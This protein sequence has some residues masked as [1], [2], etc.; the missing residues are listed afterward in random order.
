MAG[1]SN[2]WWRAKRGWYTT[3]KATGEQKPLGVRDPEDRAG[4]WAALQ[5]LLAVAGELKLAECCQFGTVAEAVPKFLAERGATVEAKTI[6]GYAQ[7]LAWLLAW[8][9]S[10]APTSVTAALLHSKAAS[11]QTWGET[12]RAN[13]LATCGAFLRWCGCAITLVLPQRGSRGPEGVIPPEVYQRMLYESRGDFRQLLRWMWETGCRP[14]EGTGLVAE[15]IDPATGTVRLKAHKTRRH[16]KTRL[17]YPAPAA[18]AVL[19]E[20]V[21][22]YGTGL[23]FRGLKGRRL[24][25][26]AM[27]MR[28]ERLSEKVGRRVCSY[29]FRHTWATRALKTGVPSAQVAAMLGTSVTMITRH[30]GHLEAEA[31][32]LRGQAE[33]VSRGA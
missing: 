13:V 30:Y 22:R 2:P 5:K 18:L 10:L 3:V 33:R 6:K 15:A 14:S 29:D 26:Q 8:A 7:H 32:L 12:H 4:A 27:T 24:S 11:V 21:E 16:G 19:A 23:L 17:I 1:L 28:F 20:Q 25:L 31:D 9:G